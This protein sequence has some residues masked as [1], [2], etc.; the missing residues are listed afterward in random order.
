MLKQLTY[1]LEQLAKANYYIEECSIKFQN[2]DQMIAFNMNEIAV[3]HQ[4]HS[5]TYIVKGDGWTKINYIFPKRNPRYRIG[6]ADTIFIP[7][8]TSNYDE[9]TNH[10]YAEARNAFKIKR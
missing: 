10:I 7:T 4:K 1:K 5:G 2:G 9:L 8:I 3:F 6:N